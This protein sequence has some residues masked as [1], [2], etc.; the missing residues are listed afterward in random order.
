M[1]DMPKPL[2]YSDSFLRTLL[3]SVKSIAVVGASANRSRPVFI[4]TKFLISK[5]FRV[6]PV[7]PGHAGGEIL[8]QTAYARLA[9][10]PEP[11][12]MIDIF[13]RPDAVPGIIDEAL[14]LEPRPKVIWMQLTIRNDEAAAK[15]EAA[16]MTVVMDRCTK[17]EYGRLVGENSWAGIVSGIIDSRRPVQTVQ[18]QRFRLPGVIDREG[19]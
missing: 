12:D 14:A 8:G 7:N 9:D 10:I 5:G 16:G 19:K 4:V 6:F 18:Y 17:I 2:A 3:G 15:A 1:S 11:I 13:R